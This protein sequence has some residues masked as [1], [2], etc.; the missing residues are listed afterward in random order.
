MIFPATCDVCGVSTGSSVSYC[1]AHWPWRDPKEWVTHFR[2]VDAIR[3]QLAEATRERD[4]WRSITREA[5][6]H[7][8]TWNVG[9]WGAQRLLDRIDAS[10]AAIRAGEAECTCAGPPDAIAHMT[11]PACPQHGKAREVR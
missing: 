2:E 4:E 5:R 6:P 10:L 1:K 7:M 9:S 3:S 8:S 11:D